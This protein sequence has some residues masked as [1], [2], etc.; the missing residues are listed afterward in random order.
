MLINFSVYA[1]VKNNLSGTQASTIANS[2]FLF[3]EIEGLDLDLASKD[4][5]ASINVNQYRGAN[6]FNFKIT[7]KFDDEYGEFANQEG[8]AGDVI[9]SIGYTRVFDIEHTS[10]AGN[11]LSQKYESALESLDSALAEC[12][13][14]EQSNDKKNG[15][16]ERSNKQLKSK[17]AACHPLENSIV[18]LENQGVKFPYSYKFG[19][20]GFSYAPNSFKYY[21]I[22][23]LETVTS[24]TEGYEGKAS[25]GFFKEY[26]D[27]A[28]IMQQ[29]KYE[30]GVAYSKQDK[31]ESKNKSQNICVPIPD[32][33]GI[34]RC[35]DSFLDP[36]VETE[37]STIFALYAVNFTHKSN[38]ILNGIQAKLS[39]AMTTT[40]NFMNEEKDYDRWIFEAPL[41]LF[42]SDDKK[43]RA[44]LTYKYRE[45]VD[46]DADDFDRSTISLFVS[47]G[48]SLIDF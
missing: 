38:V 11:T 25:Y 17:G 8:L 5:K 46:G 48:F 10:T 40:T 2:L 43:I 6:N 47:A 16:K 36:T 4:K 24:S 19:T 22:N 3:R 28:K 45:K 15:D 44:G 23:T 41:T 18:K 35:F 26:A 14:K 31:P 1:T 39:Y 21:D 13:A 42:V 7:G 20:F 37:N 33:V 30:L 27:G 34:T 12:I 29:Y 32:L 9:G